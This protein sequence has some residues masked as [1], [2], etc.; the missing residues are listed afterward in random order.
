[1]GNTIR[2]LLLM[3]S[4]AVPL[5]VAAEAMVLLQGYLG[6]GDA[7][8][9]S[10]VAAVLQEG[11]WVDG[12]HLTNTPH[13]VRQR[14][15]T[16][17]P[18]AR[19]FYTVAI[20]SQAPLLLQARQ[21]APYLE[22][23]RA[24]HPN[25]S[26]YLVGHSAGGVLARLYLVQH[27]QL[28]VSAL[29]TIASPHLGTATAEAGLLA[30]QS[31]FGWVAPLFGAEGLNRSQGLYSDLA[32]EQNGNLLYWLNRQPHPAIRY[33]SVV[34]SEN[35]FFGVGDFVVPPW[36]QDMNNVVALRGRART[37]TVDGMHNLMPAD[38]AVLLDIL[39]YLQRS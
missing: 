12:G 8:R 2:T 19:R 28:Q 20:D 1:M 7:W 3:L 10:G 25:E 11:G 21:L 9:R 27:P 15:W 34:R 24:R 31:P 35:G 33:Y 6:D 29:I 26:L 13:G 5:P 4:L 17:L 18:G 37:L 14:G 32:R 38:G 16:T 30:G 36:S 22:E 23:I 39:R